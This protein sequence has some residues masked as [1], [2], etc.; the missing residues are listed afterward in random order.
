MKGLLTRHAAFRREANNN[1]VVHPFC[2][3]ERI[4]HPLDHGFTGN[5]DESFGIAIGI[6]I[7]W[8]FRARDSTSGYDC[9][10]TFSFPHPNP[11]PSRRR[12]R[13]RANLIELLQLRLEAKFIE[14]FGELGPGQW[15]A[16][17]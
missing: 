7:K 9:I 14:H 2:T 12:A 6:G 5:I 10:H 13:A 11:S 4:Q 17:A 1:D 16:L 8:I 15:A 3:T